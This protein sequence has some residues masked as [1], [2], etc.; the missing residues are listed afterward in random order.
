MLRLLAPVAGALLLLGAAPRLPLDVDEEAMREAME[1]VALDE[2]SASAPGYAHFLQARLRHHAGDS[3]GA[4]QA[5]RA[6]LASDDESPLLRTRL[7]AEHARLGQRAAALRELRHVLALAPA[8]DEARVL[9][10]RVLLEAGRRKEAEQQLRRAIMLRPRDSAAYLALA[11]LDPQHAA[12]V[13]AR[14]AAHAPQEP[15]IHEHLGDA[16][17]ATGQLAEAAGANRPALE[18]LTA[19]GPEA[20]EPL[21]Q[22]A[23]LEQKLKMLSSRASDD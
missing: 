21:P 11:Q 22:Q 9:L 12:Q 5:L 8:H 15:L 20:G 7:A 10:A 23:S 17:R 1:A 2:E 14:A 6:A 3:R 18:A 13:L 19:L 16:L 4:L